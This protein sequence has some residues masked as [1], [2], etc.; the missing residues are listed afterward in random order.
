MLALIMENWNL[1]L[2]NLF[3]LPVR[4]VLKGASCGALSPVRSLLVEML[5]LLKLL[6]CEI[7]LLMT[8]MT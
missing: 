7:F 3:F 1:D 8:P 4:M 2:L 6:C 5:F